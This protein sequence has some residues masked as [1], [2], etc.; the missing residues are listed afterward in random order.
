[1]AGGSIF[2]CCF[3]VIH[4]VWASFVEGRE[5]GNALQK[6]VGCGVVHIGTG[7]YVSTGVIRYVCLPLRGGLL[8]LII[9]I[10]ECMERII[11][12]RV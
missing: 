2:V 7:I 1:M 10:Y 6:R 9:I 4:R 11:K 3:I 12:D 5:N 8:S